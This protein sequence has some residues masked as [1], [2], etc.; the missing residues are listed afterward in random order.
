[1]VFRRVKNGEQYKRRHSNQL[2]SHIEKIICVIRE[3]ISFYGHVQNMYENTE[4][5]QYMDKKYWKSY[6][7]TW[8]YSEWH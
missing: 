1:M 4:N 6:S 7:M 5:G 2:Y 3:N 8:N